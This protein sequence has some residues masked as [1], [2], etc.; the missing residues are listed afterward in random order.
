MLAPG[1]ARKVTICVGED[2]QYHGHALYAAVLDFLFYRGVAGATVV[3]GI[4]GFGADHKMHTTRILRLTENLPVKI[5]FIESPEKCDEVLP[6]LHEMIGTGLIEVQETLIVKSAEPPSRSEP[7]L[8]LPAAKRQGKAK[9]MRIY[10]GEND[11]WRDKPLYQALVESLR[12]NEIAGVTVYQGILGY[13][14]NRRIHQ[15]K[16]LHLSHDRPIML[17]IV[18][19][20]EKLRAFL[21]VLDDMVK[22]GLVVLSDVDI[23]KYSPEIPPAGPGKEGAR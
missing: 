2:Q 17:S 12:A 20:E 13:G 14:A 21:P 15:Q 3:R 11:K 22:Q 4:A 23:I 19:T 18:E 8:S 10:I 9:L 7:Q 16:A 6:K 5:E 1:P